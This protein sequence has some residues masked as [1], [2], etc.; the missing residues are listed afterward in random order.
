MKRI[1]VVSA[2]ALTL[3]LPLA[4]TSYAQLNYNN[5]HRHDNDR[6]NNN[7]HDNH[8]NWDPGQHNGYT[9]NGRWHYGR[10]PASITNYRPG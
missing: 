1:F 3:T 10:P 7:R 9:V 5:D 2:A 8:G 4:T 6:N